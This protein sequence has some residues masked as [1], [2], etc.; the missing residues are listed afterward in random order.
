LVKNYPDVD[1]LKIDICFLRRVCVDWNEMIGSTKLYAVASVVEEGYVGSD[2]L[3]SK[4]L[5]RGIELNF[6]K[7]G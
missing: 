3:T 1:H 2:Y 5:D 7:V 4:A 6:I